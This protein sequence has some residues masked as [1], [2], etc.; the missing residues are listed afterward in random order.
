MSL[1]IL[2]VKS[3]ERNHNYTAVS[4]TIISNFCR[5]IVG[6]NT[7]KPM[8]SVFSEKALPER[9]SEL[10][11]KQLAKEVERGDK[12]LKMTKSW[13]KYMTNASKHELV[14][15]RLKVLKS[16][17]RLIPLAYVKL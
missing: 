1:L 2:S 17:V 6:T 14:R 13:S 10:E 5:N 12:W 8:L 9:F 4:N 7:L 16:N 3:F 15:M 11:K